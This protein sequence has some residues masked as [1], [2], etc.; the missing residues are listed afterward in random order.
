MIVALQPSDDAVV[1]AVTDRLDAAGIPAAAT[2]ARWLVE[3]VRSAAPGGDGGATLAAGPLREELEALVRRRV[4]REPLQLLLGRWP[5]RTV[6]LEL[7]AGVFVP[8]PETEVVAGVA[9]EQA[10]RR[11]AAPVVAEPCTGTGAIACSLLAEV[12][13]VEVYATDRDPSAVA[14]A[15]RNLAGVMA[16]AGTTGRGEV[17]EGDLLAPLPARLRGRLDVL[18]A[19]PPYLPSGDRDALAPEVADHDP[20]G[21]LFGG[22]DG[23]EVVDRLLAAA[24]R[25]L[26]PGGAVVVE[27]DDRRGPAAC[28]AARAAGLWQVRLV[29]D[30]AGRDR[31]V[32]GTSMGFAGGAREG[33]ERPGGVQERSRVVGEA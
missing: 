18:V 6:E 19:N 10:R 14:L 32:V 17:L 23:H 26:R 28:A 29:A 12:P 22:P 30:L 11:G 27:I 1:A 21:A 3:H 13:D 24:P 15:R 20:P 9:I 25:W 31:A 2:E 4:G 8:R 33:E 16:A 7:A 5:F